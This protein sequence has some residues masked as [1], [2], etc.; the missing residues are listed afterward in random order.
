M[1]ITVMKFV[2]HHVFVE[3]FFDKQKDICLVTDR[4]STATDVVYGLT[5]PPRSQRASL[6]WGL[7]TWKLIELTS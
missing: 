7:P 3:S 5:P 2:L 4:F 6:I 1:A